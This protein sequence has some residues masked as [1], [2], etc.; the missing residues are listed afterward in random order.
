MSILSGL[1]SSDSSND[2]SNDLLGWLDVGVGVDYESESYEQSV[3]ED[4]SSHTSYDSTSFGTDIDASGLLSNM[5]DNMGGT[6]S[7]GEGFGLL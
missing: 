5:F 3:D 6:Q 1:F 2:S 4:G 7:E